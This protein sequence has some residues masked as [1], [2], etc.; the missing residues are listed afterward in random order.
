MYA[1]KIFKQ[2]D[3]L[4]ILNIQSE[5]LKIRIWSWS[6]NLLAYM[7]ATQIFKHSDWLKILSIQSECLKI[8]IA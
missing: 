6:Y 7:Y 8:S 1:M 2:S 5:C 4:K 3:W